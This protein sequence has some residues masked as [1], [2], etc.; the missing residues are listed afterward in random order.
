MKKALSLVLED[1]ELIELI[2]VLMDDD[3]DGALAWLKTHFRG[4]ARDLLEGS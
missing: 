3:V 2:R 1:D 4:K